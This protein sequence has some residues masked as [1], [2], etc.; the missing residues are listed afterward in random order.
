MVDNPKYQ[1]WCESDVPCAQVPS[2]TIEFIWEVPDP[3][4]RYSPTSVYVIEIFVQ[5]FKSVAL[6]VRTQSCLPQSDGRTDRH[7]SNVLEFC[8]DQMSPKNIGSQIIISRCYN[9]I[10]KINIHSLRS[11]LKSLKDID[12]RFSG[13]TP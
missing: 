11:R 4:N 12:M 7:S 3:V 10:D 5:I 6:C 8:A 9:R 2:I 13:S 1:I